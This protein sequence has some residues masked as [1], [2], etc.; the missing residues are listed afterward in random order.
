MKTSCHGYFTLLFIF[1][2]LFFALDAYPFV[3][4][5]GEGIDPDEAVFTTYTN[6]SQVNAFLFSPDGKTL[7][8]GT[9]GGLEKRDGFTGKRVLLYT[10][11]NGLPSNVILALTADP[12]GGIWVGTMKGL[13]FLDSDGRVDDHSGDVDCPVRALLYDNGVWAGGGSPGGYG[14]LYHRPSGGSWVRYTSQNSALPFDGV[15]CMADTAAGLFIGTYQGLALIDSGG[16]WTS[17]TSADSGLPGDHVTGICPHP[18]GG[19]FVGVENFGL[20]RFAADGQWTAETAQG[21]DFSGDSIKDIHVA[22]TGDLWFG[23]DYNGLIHVSAAGQWRRIT[24]GQSGLTSYWINAVSPQTDWTWIG[25]SNGLV[26]MSA[27][28]FFEN[29]SESRLAVGHN[30]I[31]A[32]AL[33]SGGGLWVGSSGGGM[34]R[35]T[36]DGAWEIPSPENVDFSSRWV[37]ALEADATGFWAAADGLFR[38]GLDGRLQKSHTPD[39]SSLS[40]SQ[41]TALAADAS[42]GLWIGTADRGLFYLNSDGSFQQYT[43]ADSGLPADSVLCLAV[44]A[45]GNLFAGTEGGGLARRGSGGLWTAWNTGNSELLSDDVYALCSDGSGGVWIGAGFLAHLNA[46]SVLTVYSPASAGVGGLADVKAVLPDGS[47]GVWAGIYEG[48]LAH[49]SAGSSWTLFTPADSDLVSDTIWCLETDGSGGIWMGADE[50]LAHLNFGE[51]STITRHLEQT[52]QT[53]LVQTV[54]KTSPRAAIIV[55]PRG[56][57]GTGLDFDKKNRIHPKHGGP[58]L[59]NPADPGIRPHGDLFSLP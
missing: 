59:Q 49:F 45:S 33:D 47:G 9:S 12:A 43:S 56:E 18:Q 50:G 38:F 53:E 55:H 17:W 28:N 11:H 22:A 24:P 6:T 21:V 31:R 29:L 42:G 46:A 41:L 14:G 5:A 26:R 32:M 16:Q 54:A 4:A 58:G 8:V 51:K 15:T 20:G 19:V 39:N 52:Q 25:Q 1:L 10:T 30:T 37:L 13:A 48:G 57:T 36:Q 23:T 3:K 27:D 7:W 44:D 35:L 34:G 2:H 40:T